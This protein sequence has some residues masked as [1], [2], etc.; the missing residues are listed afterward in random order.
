MEFVFV[1]GKKP[2]RNPGFF[3]F[4]GRT[5]EAYKDKFMRLKPLGNPYKVSTTWVRDK[6]EEVIDI[7]K[8]EVERSE[9]MIK[10]LNRAIYEPTDEE[11]EAYYSTF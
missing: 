3:V 5:P 1:V 4:K 6:H 8:G 9:K 7:L 11:R 2:W 10:V